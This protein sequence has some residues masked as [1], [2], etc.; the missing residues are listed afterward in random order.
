M[1][2]LSA[3]TIRRLE[4]L[5]PLL[6]RTQHPESGCSFG[7]SSCGYDIRLDQDVELRPGEFK[8]ASTLERFQ[9]PPNVVGIVHDKSTWIRRGLC[10]FN[11]VIEPGWYGYLTLEL[12]NV[13]PETEFHLPRPGTL[14]M[15]KNN[16]P[17]IKM[18]AGTPVAQVIFSFLDETTEQA[19]EGKYQDQQRGPVEAKDGHGHK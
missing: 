11:T 6:P 19:Y 1:T 17:V 4:P 8:L 9:M 2:V 14:G 10:V 3:Q 7:L 12:K 15:L 5:A 18:I 13:N 16:A